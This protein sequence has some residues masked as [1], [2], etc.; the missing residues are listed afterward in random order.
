[1]ATP[2]NDPGTIVHVDF[3]P[4]SAEERQLREQLR[5][6]HE[7][8]ME[9]ARPLVERLAALRALKTPRLILVSDTTGLAA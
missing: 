6:L 1:M 8:Y 4:D 5:M 2:F 3:G 7:E 9:R